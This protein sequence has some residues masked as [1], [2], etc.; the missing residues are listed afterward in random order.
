MAARR[1]IVRRDMIPIPCTESAAFLRLLF[2]RDVVAA[3][4]QSG[5]VDVPGARRKR[6]FVPA[7]ASARARADKRHSVFHR[8]K[9]IHPLTILGDTSGEVVIVTDRIRAKE[10]SI[11]AV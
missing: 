5:S 8:F 4:F 10:L 7:F 6:V 9:P 2:T 3:Q 1:T 11:G